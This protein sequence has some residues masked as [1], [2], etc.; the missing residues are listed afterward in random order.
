MNPRPDIPDGGLGEGYL[1]LAAVPPQKYGPQAGINVI[2]LVSGAG[3][4]EVADRW[5]GSALAVLGVVAAAVSPATATERAKIRTASF[6]FSNLIWIG[7]V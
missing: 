6:I 4:G 1:L 7:M 5:L 2:E 3:R